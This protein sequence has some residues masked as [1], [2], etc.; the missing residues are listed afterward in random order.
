MAVAFLGTRLAGTCR[1][2]RRPNTDPAAAQRL[3]ARSPRTS[4]LFIGRGRRGAGGSPPNTLE[5]CDPWPRN[6]RV[7]YQRHLDWRALGCHR[8]Q[9]RQ[10]FSLQGLKSLPGKAGPG[11][12]AELRPLCHDDI[13]SALMNQDIRA[14]S[15]I[16]RATV[17]SFTDDFTGQLRRARPG[18]WAFKPRRC[19]SD[20]RSAVRL[21]SLAGP[22]TALEA[23]RI[24]LSK[25]AIDGFCMLHGVNPVPSVASRL[26]Y[27][28]GRHRHL[29]D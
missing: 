26:I 19:H 4:V 9:E 1:N 11:H 5:K 16:P 6:A 10:N 2:E 25:A 7:A 27:N 17:V 14:E 18:G 28:G 3:L 8:H 15:T 12:L 13:A 24:R 22:G 21:A 29:N 20:A 23:E